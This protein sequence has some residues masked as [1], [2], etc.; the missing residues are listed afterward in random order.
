LQEKLRRSEESRRSTAREYDRNIAE[1]HVKA[2][3]SYQR[4]QAGFFELREEY[5]ARALEIDALN[6]QLS[7]KESTIEKVYVIKNMP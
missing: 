4:G 3:T 5:D 7:S 6:E 2:D 1:L